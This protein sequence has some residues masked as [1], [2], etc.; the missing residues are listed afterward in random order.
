MTLKELETENLSEKESAEMKYID[1]QND[2][3]HVS[4]KHH[5]SYWCTIL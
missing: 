4:I 2:N 1:K 3:E 5:Y